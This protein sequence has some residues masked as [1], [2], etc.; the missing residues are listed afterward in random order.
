MRIAE[1]EKIK[2]LA[3]YNGTSCNLCVSIPR[4]LHNASK[5]EMTKACKTNTSSKASSISYKLTQHSKI[6]N[7]PE[8]S[9]F[10][11]WKTSISFAYCIAALG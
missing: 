6:E 5:A 7:S 3:R 10:Q 11:L 8:L 1:N 4:A 2:Y 9:I